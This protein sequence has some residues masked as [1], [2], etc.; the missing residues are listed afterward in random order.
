MNLVDMANDQ[1]VWP[2]GRLRRR[3]EATLRQ[4]LTEQDEQRLDRILRMVAAG[5]KTLTPAQSAKL[6]QAENLL[7]QHATMLDRALAD[8]TLLAEVLAHEEAAMADAKLSLILD[9]REETQLL[10][11]RQVVDEATGETR[12]E[13]VAYGTLP[14]IEAMPGP[15]DI[16]DGDGG[17]IRS[18][19]GKLVDQ[20]QA[21]RDQMAS[22]SPEAMVFVLARAEGS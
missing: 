17:T 9:G 19:R 6:T 13:Q 1:A 21:A 2:T 3:A 22:T 18:A 11:D 12:I 14:A 16:S 15:N 7:G 5:E 10:V 8:N 4:K 20:R